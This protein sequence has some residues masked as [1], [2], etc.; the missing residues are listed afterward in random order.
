MS[1]TLTPTPVSPLA[2]S[3]VLTVRPAQTLHIS[4]ATMDSVF[5]H[6]LSVT[7]ILNVKREKMRICQCAMMS[8]LN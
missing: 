6:N 3:L 4:S 8:I 1:L 7:A 5:I 2:P